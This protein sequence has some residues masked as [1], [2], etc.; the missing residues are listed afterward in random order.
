MKLTK[1]NVT[2]VFIASG[3]LFLVGVILDI[4]ALFSIYNE[5]GGKACANKACSIDDQQL[6]IQLA[7]GV[8]FAG[9]I[10]L[11]AA[12]F[13][14]TRLYSKRSKAPSKKQNKSH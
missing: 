2:K 3:V 7:K 11:V 13:L 1:K 9:L 12:M 4:V 10:V 8:I 14:L 5:V 6:I